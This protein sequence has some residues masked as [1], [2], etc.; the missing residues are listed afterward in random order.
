MAHPQTEATKRKISLANKGRKPSDDQRRRQSE[1]RKRL[2]REGNLRI[3]WA[4]TKGIVT[5]NR[6]GADS[7]S[8]KGGRQRDKDGYI[9]LRLPDH[10]NANSSGMVAE[11]RAVMAEKLGH[12]LVAGWNVHH[13]NGIRDD[14]RP[15][16]L[17]I[18]ASKQPSMQ[19]LDDPPH[20]PTCDCEIAVR[21]MSQQVLL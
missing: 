19:R 10:P 7:S 13:K 8:W 12:P 6:K 1:T 3:P 20:C 16:N 18:W 4:G 17:E 2:F 15:E 9:W 11:H 21:R 14:N 5:W